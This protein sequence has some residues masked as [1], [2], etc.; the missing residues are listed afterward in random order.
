MIY[1]YEH[2][3]TLL[4]VRGFDNVTIGRKL[5]SLCGFSPL[6]TE[7]TEKKEEVLGLLPKALVGQI[8]LGSN[9]QKYIPAIEKNLECL[10]VLDIAEA[11]PV[12]LQKRVPAWDEAL[13][14]ISDAEVR[15]AIQSLLVYD[16]QLAEILEVMNTRYSARITLEG[17]QMYTKYF[18]NVSRMSRLELFHFITNMDSSKSRVALLEA[19]HRKKDVV[20][21]KY[22]GE[23]VLTF[24]AILKEVMN[25]AFIKFRTSVKEGSPDD[26]GKV[27]QWAG[28][29]MRAAEKY[30]KLF[31]KADVNLLEQLQYELEKRSQSTIPMKDT[32]DGEVL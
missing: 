11:T 3:L 26:F 5:K 15:V 30:D 13:Y 31:K 20:Q 16:M 14:I 29:A 25:E 2:Y 18:W 12:L 1:P 22:I 9:N 8:T 4:I 21:W 24:E 17:L 28:L 23:N 6:D 27:S 32:V 10:G 7:I 19:F